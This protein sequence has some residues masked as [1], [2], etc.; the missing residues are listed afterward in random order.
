MVI[1]KKRATKAKTKRARSKPPGVDR[2]LEILEYRCDITQ[3]AI[4]R[5]EVRLQALETD[6]R[7]QKEARSYAIEL[8]ELWATRA[9]LSKEIRPEHGPEQ[10]SA[11]AER[12]VSELSKARAEI[13][14]LK[15]EIV[16]LHGGDPDEFDPSRA[17]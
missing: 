17:S 6:M 13:E 7:W 11:T 9:Q 2:T 12:L 16:T 10:A 14:A 5:I 4:E 1:R 3:R 8:G 15:R